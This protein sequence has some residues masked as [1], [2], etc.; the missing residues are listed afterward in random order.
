VGVDAINGD[1]G[2]GN[3]VN[4]APTTGVVADASLAVRGPLVYATLVLIVAA[5]PRARW[6]L[7][8]CVRQPLVWSYVQPVAVSA[9]VALIVT[10]AFAFLLL[11]TSRSG[12]P[13]VDWPLVVRGYD[14]L[15]ARHVDRPR[16]A[17][18]AFGI[19]LLAGLAILPQ[20][21]ARAT[22]P[23][24]AGSRPAGALAGS[25]RCR[26]C[27]HTASAS[28]SSVPCPAFAMSARTSDAR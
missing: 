2:A 18:V 20:L 6:R 10:P 9:A 27:P 19:L 16:G 21:T 17:Y 26:R 12:A 13:P 15:I 22:L 11:R 8:G 24:A 1:W 4:P 23:E 25:R 28:R 14:K 3:S 5:V 7:I